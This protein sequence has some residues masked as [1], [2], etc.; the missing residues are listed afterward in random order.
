MRTWSLDSGSFGPTA[1]L[2]LRRFDAWVRMKELGSWTR[3]AKYLLRRCAAGR[4]AHPLRRRPGRGRRDCARSPARS[5]ARSR[6][7][8]RSTRR[9]LPAAA[10]FGQ[11]L[12][13][14]QVP[15]VAAH[16][17]PQRLHRDARP[18]ATRALPDRSTSGDI[19][20]KGKAVGQQCT[21]LTANGMTVRSCG[22]TGSTPPATACRPPRAPGASTSPDSATARRIISVNPIVYDPSYVPPGVITRPR[23]R[24]AS[25][26]RG[27][28]PASHHDD[29]G[30]RSG[31]RDCGS[32]LVRPF[33]RLEIG[34][35]GFDFHGV[36]GPST[37]S[38]ASSRSGSLR[39]RGGG[40]ADL[41]LA[42]PGD[43][44]ERHLDRPA[45]CARRPGPAP[46]RRRPRSSTGSP[47]ACSTRSTAARA[48]LGSSRTS[49]PAVSRK[50]DLVDRRRARERGRV[51]DVLKIPSRGEQPRAVDREPGER[52]ADEQRADDHDRCLTRLRRRPRLTVRSGTGRPSPTCVASTGIE[53][54]DQ[55]APMNG[56]RRTGTSVRTCTVSS[57]PRARRPSTLACSEPGRQPVVAR[58]L[59]DH[60]RATS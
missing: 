14:R 34:I 16:R 17:S 55:T 44:E 47:D 2:V 5:R 36:N 59:L 22:S 50:C 48:E 51:G 30:L 27:R 35:C 58:R 4:P 39:A 3:R 28:S 57:S 43:A 24:R 38:S 40:R 60:Q 23:P 7:P 9:Q 20:V 10:G 8:R 54:D 1:A 32:L 52:E 42:Q 45:R 11:E 41:L 19:L 6:P 21:T 49:R 46:R 31:P 53:T 12:P 29:R 13:A 33:A 15:E 56:M 18:A 26:T 37:I 25:R